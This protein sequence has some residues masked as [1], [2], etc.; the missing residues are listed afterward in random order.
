MK[1]CIKMVLMCSFVGFV[2]LLTGCNTVEGLGK[3]MQE[4]GKALSQSAQKNS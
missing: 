4:G 1:R 2:F 3:D